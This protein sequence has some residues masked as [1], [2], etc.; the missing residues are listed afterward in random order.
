MS[1]DYLFKIVMVG[2]NRV[3][4]TSYAD[5]L[6][7]ESYHNDYRATLGVDFHCKNILLHD[8]IVIKTHIWDTAGQDKFKPIVEIYYKEVAGAIIMY[9]IT[10]KHSFNR[11]NVWKERINRGQNNNL[12]MPTILIGCKTDMKSKREVSEKEAQ[13]YANNNNMLYSEISNKDNKNIEETY[14]RL[15]YDIFFKMDDVNL[16]PGIKRHFSQEERLCDKDHV[17]ACKK[18]SL[19][20][21][22]II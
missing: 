2:D 16:S 21:C 1:Y 10:N 7:S 17:R 9:D 3:G 5:R 13:E 12:N 18:M 19:T 4:K 20:C 15:I 6:C 11:V 8:N 14:K 22:T